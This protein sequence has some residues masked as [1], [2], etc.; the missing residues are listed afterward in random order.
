M[1]AATRGD[2]KI[3]YLAV[4]TVF[5]G[6]RTNDARAAERTAIRYGLKIPVGHDVGPKGSR[7]PVMSK[8]RTG[9][10]PWFVIIDTKG[11]VRANAFHLRVDRA[12]RYIKSL[13]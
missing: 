11:M 13:K 2:K 5:E 9:G 12:V 10:T 3:S 7:S 4:Q 1:I 8:Y 6:Y